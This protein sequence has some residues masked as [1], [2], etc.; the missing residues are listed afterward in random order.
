MSDGSRRTSNEAKA[1]ILYQSKQRI[2]GRF[3]EEPGYWMTSKGVLLAYWQD[4]DATQSVTFMKGKGS[5]GN[6][7]QHGKKK[8]TCFGCGKDG[9]VVRNCRS[10]NKTAR[11]LNA[12]TDDQ[13]G[14]KALDVASRPSTSC[15]AYKGGGRV[16]RLED[17]PLTTTGRTDDTPELAESS[18]TKYETMAKL[19]EE[20]CPPNSHAD[21]HSAE[22]LNQQ[23][24]ELQRYLNR[25]P[26]SYDTG[27]AGAMMEM[28]CQFY[29]LW[30]EVRQQG[31]NDIS[32]TF[33]DFEL[34]AAE[35][36]WTERVEYSWEIGKQSLKAEMTD[37]KLSL[38]EDTKRFKRKTKKSRPDE[39]FYWMDYRNQNHAKLSWI[40]CI[41]DHCITHYSD[42]TGTGWFPG[43]LKG[44]ARCQWAWLECK[45]DQCP[46]H[47][48]DKRKS[49][50]F[51]GHDDPQDIIQ[52][53]EIQQ[54]NHGEGFAWECNQP[55]WHTCLNCEC[56]IHYVAK[57]LYGFGGKAALDQ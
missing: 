45:N 36:D 7:N 6:K 57:D 32:P 52:M 14:N 22:L 13:A 26:I 4:H 55:G 25:P 47:L 11:Q 50:C 53:Q 44:F 38:L 20:H 35:L 30:K 33:Q 56:D 31:K 43:S 39:T 1:P 40:A 54:K 2:K 8:I 10:R 12:K 34:I 51:P 15:V 24:N 48:W 49:P 5:V 29:K 19:K 42:K 41:H 9:H 46:S 16:T 37:E 3:L 23:I 17:F 18:H 27:S 21:I 28:Q